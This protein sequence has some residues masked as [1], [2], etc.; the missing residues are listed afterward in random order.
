VQRGTIIMLGPPAIPPGAPIAPAPISGVAIPGIPIPARPTIIAV[1]MGFHPRVALPIREQA[2]PSDPRGLIM[3]ILLGI[4]TCGTGQVPDR[5]SH[6]R[7]RSEV[8]SAAGAGT[9]RSICLEFAGS[10]DCEGN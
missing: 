4:S 9:G 6:V 5:C 3:A 10:A 7:S 1:V 2:R 8:P